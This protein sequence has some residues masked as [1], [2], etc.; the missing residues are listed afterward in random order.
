[1]SVAPIE[2]QGIGAAPGI[3]IGRIHLLDRRKLIVPHVHIDED[4]IESEISR[5]KVALNTSRKQIQELSAKVALDGQEHAAIIDAHLMMLED[6]TLI[7]ETSNRI[8][9]E[10][11]N[12]EWAI[13]E[14][15]KTLGALLE[16][17]ESGYL[18]E[19]RTDLD[20]VGQRVIRNL[21]GT[22]SAWRQENPGNEPTV[23]VAHDLSPADTVGLS[24]KSIAAFATEV[25]SR[26]SH[27]SIVAR[28]MDV[29][30]VVGCKALYKRAGH[31]DR[32]IVD[33]LSGTIILHPNQSQIDQARIKQ[34]RFNTFADDLKRQAFGIAKTKNE[35]PVRVF[36]NIETPH[37]AKNVT[38][39]G[40]NGIGLYRSEFLF[41]GRTNLPNEEEHYETYRSI[42]DSIGDFPVT[43]RTFDLGGDKLFG[44]AKEAPEAN[45][46]LG[47][48]GLRF[49]LN[50]GDIFIPQLKGLLRAATHG[51]LRILF[52]MVTEVT[53]LKAAKAY[54][55]LACE[56]LR[57]EGKDF[58]HDVQIG[59]MVEIPSMVFSL[60]EFLSRTDFLSVGTNDL[61]QYLTAVD[62][63]N[64]RVAHLYQ[65]LHSGV[66]HTLQTIATL[67]TKHNHPVTVCGELAGE[68]EYAPI[69]LGMGYQNFSM[70]ASTIPWVKTALS[71]LDQRDCKE[72][73]LRMLDASYMEER[74][75][76]L[77]E[78]C[79]AK[80]PKDLIELGQHV[81]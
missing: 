26:T 61:M 12:A 18:R 20:F 72:V 56:Q 60:H 55:K 81:I 23:L 73:V 58:K 4:Q 68:V 29:P 42:F 32:I 35:V 76:M 62:R 78:F 24:E 25:G 11:V 57:N 43:I 27:T 48:R 77:I 33:G 67:C 46:A 6:P 59:C 22:E 39:R 19:R 65:P 3:V 50:H 31:K 7:Q 34:T 52:P 21:T 38:S 74:A 2:I 44:A 63:T 30:A 37:E 47:L 9:N 70:N 41:V 49:C 1:M 66:M 80:L 40:G 15:L 28:S 16:K 14:T 53:E 10:Q 75:S 64:E 45:P 8:K 17:V 79:E 51:D 69:L 5:F 54:L 71:H 13:Q 36:G